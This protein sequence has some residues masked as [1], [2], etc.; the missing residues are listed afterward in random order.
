MW[1]CLEYGL[2]CN[3]YEYSEII[4]PPTIYTMKILRPEVQKTLVFQG[5]MTDLM[6]NKMKFF[7]NITEEELNHICKNA[8]EEELKILPT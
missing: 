1:T 8:S 5:G 6:D 7:Y 2:A 3:R 4:H